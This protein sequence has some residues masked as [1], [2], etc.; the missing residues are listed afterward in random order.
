VQTQERFG[1]TVNIPGKSG[2]T[3]KR[4][5]G[6][7]LATAV[8][9]LCGVLA[10]ACSAR[11]DVIV[12]YSLTST[13]AGGF[14][15]NS[16]AA[17]VSASNITEQSA[18][19]NFATGH[20]AN[21]LTGLN[22]SPAPMTHPATVDAAFAAND[23]FSF[24]VTPPPGF[25]FNLTSL[26][27]NVVSGGTANFPPN[28]RGTGVRSSLTDGTDLSTSTP[29]DA[30]LPVLERSPIVS[31][32][33]PAFQNI[34]GPVTFTFA[35]QTP[36]GNDTIVFNDITLNG[37]LTPIPEPASLGLWL[38]FGVAGAGSVWRKWRNRKAAA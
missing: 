13:G 21:G 33:S 23:T 35:V 37:T 7:I 36:N 30:L 9:A 12:F 17:G 4:G 25:Q 19:Q 22:A 31:L 6:R 11:A 16:F 15:P 26:T 5:L 8:L 1:E 2:G 27:F 29:V 3:P 18:L 38:S 20:T 32:S 34:T 28:Q 10:A 24:T 14:Q